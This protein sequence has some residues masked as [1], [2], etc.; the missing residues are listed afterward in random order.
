[1]HDVAACKRMGIDRASYEK[2]IDESEHEIDALRQ[3]L[4]V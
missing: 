2:L 3:A 1:M 4:G